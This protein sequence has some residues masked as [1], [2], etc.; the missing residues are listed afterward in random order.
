MVAEEESGG[1]QGGA[2]ALLSSSPPTSYRLPTKS[3]FLSESTRFTVGSEPD[4]ACACSVPLHPAAPAVS[5][6]QPLALRTRSSSRHSRTRRAPCSTTHS[7]HPPRVASEPCRD[8]P[9]MRPGVARASRSPAHPRLRELANS[10]VQEPSGSTSSKSCSKRAFK[11]PRSC[12]RSVSAPL[13]RS[14]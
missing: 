8:S 3:L 4:N 12:A 1:C 2:A 7:D 13:L 11:S 9:H 14:L 10:G 5:R 6:S